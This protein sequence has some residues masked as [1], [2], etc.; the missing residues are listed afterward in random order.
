MTRYKLYSL[1]LL[2]LLILASCQNA[3]IER[4]WCYKYDFRVSASGINI[5]QGSHVPGTGILTTVDGVLQM[6]WTHNQVVQPIEIV[7]TAGRA[8]GV[9]GDVNVLANADVFGVQIAFNE[10][11][12]AAAPQFFELPFRPSSA[13]QSGNAVNVSF[14]ASQQMILQQLEIRG[15]GLN[16]FPINYCGQFTPSPSPT[17]TLPY[18][19]TP[20][21]TTTP[22]PTLTNTPG[23]S[24]TPTYVYW[25]SP[26]IE[27]SYIKNFSG[28]SNMIPTNTTGYEVVPVNNWVVGWVTDIDD[29]ESWTQDFSGSWVQPAAITAGRAARWLSATSGSGVLVTAP[30]NPDRII[31]TFAG[32]TGANNAGYNQTN[33]AN[34]ALASHPTFTHLNN[35][36]P[37]TYIGGSTLNFAMSQQNIRTTGTPTF[38]YRLRLIYFGVPVNPTPTPSP[39]S[40]PTATRTPI[41]VPPVTISPT[42]T[43]LVLATTT[44]RPSP[45]LAPSSTPVVVT[46]QPTRTLIPPPTLPVPATIDPSD[47]NPNPTGENEAEWN[48]LDAINDFFTDVANAAQDGADFLGRV[49]NWA[50]GTVN[51]AM[52]GIGNIVSTIAGVANSVVRYVTDLF[53]SGQLTLDLTNALFRISGGWLGGA[54]TRLNNIIV[55]FFNT[56]ASPIPGLPQCITNPQAHDL[57]AFWYMLDWTIFAPGT[58][59]QYIVPVLTIVM[60]IAIVL[61]FVNLALKMLRRVEMITRVS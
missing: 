24:P 12:P 43:P 16:P 44:A 28:N 20:V 55:A 3:P 46:S 29:T 61:Y 10:T 30:A 33:A 1:L 6:N 35:A 57:C 8:S 49:V 22:S 18:T 5:I 50:N 36:G 58:P 23:P 26:W 31:S 59:G 14:Q 17:G 7:V 41:F 15:Q 60:N 53:Q 52:T 54:T 56:P 47:P 2:P 40:T 19:N 27:Y 13:G 42:R 51:N 21:P 32:T 9:T 11:L 37:N 38:T 39:T 34:F 45:T 4:D 48:I 25:M